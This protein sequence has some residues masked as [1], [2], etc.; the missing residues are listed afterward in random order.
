MPYIQI[1]MFKTS[2]RNALPYLLFGA[3][4]AALPASAQFNKTKF[5]FGSSTSVKGAKAVGTTSRFTEATGYGFE[6]ETGKYKV[7]V[8]LGDTKGSDKPDGN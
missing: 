2:S 3:L 1:F 7:T 4:L 5:I 8:T 6:Y